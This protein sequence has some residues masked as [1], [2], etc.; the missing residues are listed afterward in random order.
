MKSKLI[1]FEGIDGSGKSTQAKMLTDKLVTLGYDAVY[2]FE[3]T[4]KNYGKQL[5]DS[6]F[7][8]RLSPEEELNLFI[9]D[10][11]E[12]IEQEITPW[13]ENNKIVVIDRYMYSSIAYQGALGIDTTHIKNLHNNF[14]LEPDLIFIFKSNVDDCLSRIKKN[15]KATDQFEKKDY[16]TKVEDIFRLF[17]GSKFIHINSS[18][19]IENIHTEILDCFNKTL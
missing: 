8:G 4:N 9:K 5:R 6:F 14:I 3:P 16:L 13:L 2:T 7:S 18:E 12:H 17:Q 15:R 10:R 1:V 11:K 19:S